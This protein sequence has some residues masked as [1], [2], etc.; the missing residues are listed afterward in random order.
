MSNSKVLAN[1]VD[2]FYQIH[3][4]VLKHIANKKARTIFTE[5]YVSSSS[6]RLIIRSMQGNIITADS[7][8]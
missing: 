3:S 5:L 2:I 6:L 1:L 7:K 8:F 4:K